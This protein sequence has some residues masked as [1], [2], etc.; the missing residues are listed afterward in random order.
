M[1]RLWRRKCTWWALA[2]LLLAAGA[3]ATG[4]L[5]LPELRHLAAAT[6]GTSHPETAA[7]PLHA[8]EQESD[9]AGHDHDAEAEAAGHPDDE[10]HAAANYDHPHDEAA[11]LSLSKQ[12]KANIGVRPVRVELRTF[13]RT[14]TV[15]GI[16]VER[17]GWTTLEVTAPMTGVVTRIYPIQGEAVEP[18]Q[19]L[20]EVRLTHE[21]L[22]QKQT[23]FLRGVEELDVITREVGR[24]EKVASDG[25]IAGKTLLERKYEQQ[26]HQAALRAQR[27]ALLLH[28]LSKEQVENIE[29]SRTL[30]QS[31]VVAVPLRDSAG[32]RP[33]FPATMVRMVPEM[34]LSPSASAADPAAAKAERPA[35]ISPKTFQVQELKVSQGS[36]VT[37]GSILCRLVDHAELYI[38]GKAFEEDVQAINQA[39]A[40]G[41]KVSASLGPKPAGGNDAVQGLGIR[42]LDDKVDP[43]SRA[44]RFYVALP[45]QVVREDKAP[46]GRRFVYWRF[47]PGQRTQLQVP[48]ET[49]PDRIVL[50]VD[51]VAQDG[52]EFYVFEAN[53]DHFD[54]RPVHVEYRDQQWVVIANDG[55]LRPGVTAAG[56]AAHQMQMA[57]KSKAEG[58][59]DPHAG[60]N[61]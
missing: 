22:L 4:S 31:L 17:P 11:A 40:K 30:L 44:F 28:G 3:A 1:K 27:Q 13:E 7:A 26:K 61:H 29:T 52:V 47:K 43:E 60:H 19:P 5:W 58:A 2:L 9:Q 46:D 38:E 35:S 42:Y 20:F 36:Y 12:A 41:W 51:A 59:V 39:A 18:G 23:D 8:D 56:S 37:A 50:P 21:D 57:M 34:G 14:I 54:R 32:D 16:V 15:P 25:A 10:D 24:L 48:V 53:G 6:L 45:N 33:D 55:A 49:W